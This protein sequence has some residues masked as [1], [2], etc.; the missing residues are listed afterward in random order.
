MRMMAQRKGE[1]GLEC[2]G[3]SSRKQLA[4]F[5]GSLF[6]LCT[7]SF[8]QCCNERLDGLVLALRGHI[9]SWMGNT[10]AAAGCQLF[11]LHQS[12]SKEYRKWSQ[13]IKTQGPP[14]GTYFL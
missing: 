2:S 14:S 13:V 6:N 10:A 7:S 1:K 12:G 4:T 5:Q 8:S 9:L 3:E 11:I